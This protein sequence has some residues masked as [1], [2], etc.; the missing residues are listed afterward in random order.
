MILPALLKDTI[1]ADGIRQVHAFWFGPLGKD[2]LPRKD[3]SR[4]WFRADRK[5]DDLIRQ[6]FGPL[7]DRAARGE[8]KDWAQTAQGRLALIL[9]C[10]QFSRNMYRGTADAFAHDEMALSLCTEGIERG[11]DR[12]L[13]PIERAFFYMPMEHCEDL[14]MQDRCVQSYEQLLKDVP[15]ATASRLR[16][17]MQHAYN[18]R[19]IIRR[20][21]RFP[22]RNRVLGRRSTD[23]EID[24]LR[25]RKATFG[26]G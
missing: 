4:L 5:S 20:F 22:H 12:E 3:R 11:H 7:L 19:D 18:H 8:L 24:F 15:P 23:A 10:D 16:S 1:L 26:Q 6:R 9:L 17:F 14:S 25:T 13:K 21:G 2:D